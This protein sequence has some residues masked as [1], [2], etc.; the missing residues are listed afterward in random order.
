M[1]EESRAKGVAERMQKVG[2]VEIRDANRRFAGKSGEEVYK[3]QCTACHAS[4][5]AG[6]PKVGDAAAWG[7]R[8]KTGYEALLNSALKGK[9]AMGPQ[10]GG[11]FQRRG[12]RPRGGLHGQPSRRQTGRARRTGRRRQ[13]RWCSGCPGGRRADTGTR[14]CTR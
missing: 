10:G 4:G 2:S 9:G 7:P 3:A 14:R 1:S 13:R 12:N 8:I 6:A 11:E 5:V